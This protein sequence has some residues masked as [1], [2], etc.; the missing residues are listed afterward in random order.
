MPRSSKTK[1]A[2]EP[3]HEPTP[4]PIPPS[5]GTRARLFL[6]RPR[7]L[8]LLAT[9]VSSTVVVPLLWEQLPDLGEAEQ[10]RVTLDD[11]RISQPPAWVP[12]DLAEQ[13][14]ERTA[15]PHELSLLEADLIVRLAQGFAMHPWVEEVVRVRKSFPARIDVELRFR[16]PVAMVK[17]KHGMYP[18]DGEGVLLP[19]A[20]FA[21]SQTRLYPL[22][23]NVTSTPQGP[24]GTNWGDPV[25]LGAAR[26]ADSLAPHWKQFG[27]AAIQAP[28]RTKA[29]Q[30]AD[31]LSYQLITTGGSRILWGRAPGTD[32]P[33]ELTLEQK[34]GRLE[35]YRADFGGFDQPHGP[36]EID[37]RHW[38]E[39]S[40]RPL[41]TAR[42]P[43]RA[44][45]L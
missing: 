29:D 3:A 14:W 33:G 1:S 18:V 13:V 10:Y 21:V 44:A 17:V 32:H 4:A 26:L 35:K 39:I 25:V 38:Q 15:L 19:P 30:S 37:I 42:L 16:R 6:F 40:R 12:R 11:V 27:L 7:V 5:F 36:Y 23:T 41:S 34:V 20:D 31:E 43:N 24:A 2:P 45:N 9:L 22:V 28:H 8:L